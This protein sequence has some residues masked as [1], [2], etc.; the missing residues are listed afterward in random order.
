LDCAEASVASPAMEKAISIAKKYVC[1][2]LTFDLP[3]C[4]TFVARDRWVHLHQLGR[5]ALPRTE[6]RYLMV[7][8]LPIGQT[9]RCGGGKPRFQFQGFSRAEQAISWPVH[10][11]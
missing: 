11:G 5:P 10:G 7:D 9:Q 6:R 8:H 2:V 1:T 3:A 4:V